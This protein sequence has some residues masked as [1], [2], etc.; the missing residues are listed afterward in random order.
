LF[1]TVF[2]GPPN[3]FLRKFEHT[4]WW[5]GP[6]V[7]Y[8]DA[9]CPIPTGKTFRNTFVGFAL[10][11][12]A[13]GAIL[14][15]MLG[16]AEESSPDTEKLVAGNTEFA[17]DLYSKLRAGD[18]NIFFSPYGIST[19]PAMASGGARGETEKQIWQTLHFNLAPDILHPTFATLAASLQTLQEKGQVTLA[20]AHSL[21]PQQGFR[22]LPDYLALCQTNYGISVK[23][24]GYQGHTEA[25]RK[26]I[27]DWV[28]DRTN[29]KIVELLKPGLLG[30][31]TRLVLVNALYFKGK[32][33]RQ[34][35]A[36]L[37]ASEP[38]HTSAG[39]QV[40]VPL[41]RQT[42]VFGHAEFPDRQVLQLP[43]AGDELAMIALLPRQMD[44]LGKLET[45][46][47]LQNP[48]S[49]NTSLRSE[50]VQVFLPKFKTTAQLDLAN[51]LQSL[52]MSD[53]FKAKSAGFPHGQSRLQAGAPKTEARSH[54]LLRPFRDGGE[55]VLQRAEIILIEVKHAVA[56]G[57]VEV[58]H[59]A[60]LHP[61]GRT[62]G[63]QLVATGGR[64]RTA[65][66]VR[67]QGIGALIW[68]VGNGGIGPH[69][70]RG[71]QHQVRGQHPAGLG[72]GGFTG[73]RRRI[74]SAIVSP[75]GQ[76]AH[77]LIPHGPRLRVRPYI[78]GWQSWPV[79]AGP[80]GRSRR[81]PGGGNAVG[82]EAQ[83]RGGG[84]QIIVHFKRIL[85]APARVQSAGFKIIIV[86]TGVHQAAH[87]QLFQISRTQ[88]ALAL[89]LGRRQRRQQHRRQDG[90]DGDDHEQLDQGER[91]TKTTLKLHNPT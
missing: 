13:V 80:D 81:I 90:N 15:A 55:V 41:M 37:T 23:P 89:F 39:S 73:T 78:G 19:A 36:P 1:R 87:A 21:W 85:P 84:K 47:T 24:V 32:W 5:S 9:A 74:K 69:I 77:I 3:V 4:T 30:K 72:L 86:V 25:A 83:L 66:P 59:G 51:T 48:T 7:L 49:G 57:S 44:G 16:H 26:S 8:N 22:L 50:Q 2:A 63:K 61:G 42:G 28:A 12:L 76:P 60:G 65:P 68:L 88:G 17:L 82:F 43:H 91:P 64:G 52:G 54:R 35:D 70:V 33:T 27:N 34:F 38:F 40:N 10:T 6:N 67:R 20:T 45:E 79:W 29:R 62:V 14:G 71:G 11:G 18:G 31:S 58:Q 56:F 75:V 53:A 46:L